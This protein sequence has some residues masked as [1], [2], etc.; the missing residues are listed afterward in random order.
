MHNGRS[1]SRICNFCSGFHCCEARADFRVQTSR[2]YILSHDGYF[3]TTQGCNI[4]DAPEVPCDVQESCTV[5]DKTPPG[6]IKR[7][8]GL[9]RDTDYPH[10]F[11][12]CIAGGMI[13]INQETEGGLMTLSSVLRPASACAMDLECI[14]PKHAI[15]IINS[16]FDMAPLGLLVHAAGVKY[17]GGRRFNAALFS[18]L[19]TPEAQVLFHQVVLYTRRR[20]ASCV[21]R[22]FDSI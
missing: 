14:Y 1:Q 18:A 6:V 15:A 3:F 9:E 7:L 13:G 8:F 17:H 19:H 11:A 10:L 12:P 4:G 21:T 22:S 16:N 5:G 2:R 20:L